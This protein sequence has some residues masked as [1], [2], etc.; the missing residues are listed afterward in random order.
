[1]I[2]VGAEAGCPPLN[3]T[4]IKVC[5][6]GNPMPRKGIAITY[7]ENDNNYIV[8]DSVVLDKNF[9]EM[10]PGEKKS[11][12][13]AHHEKQALFLH[14]LPIHKSNS[15]S[16]S[17]ATRESAKNMPG[18][19]N[20]YYLDPVAFK[21]P[22]IQYDENLLY[23]RFKGEASKGGLLNTTQAQELIIEFGC[24]GIQG[25]TQV[26]ITI[27]ITMHKPIILYMDKEC[28]KETLIDKIEEI[29]VKEEES[30]GI[31]KFIGYVILIGG[32]IFTVITAVNLNSGKKLVDSVPIGGQ[33]LA[34]IL[35][36]VFFNIFST[37]KGFNK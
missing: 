17:L 25:K 14:L 12:I 21:P 15:A 36:L 20:N 2:K 28:S 37:K 8:R 1:M 19:L 34:K 32:I 4:W 22:K 7:H 9:M 11:V 33:L 23:P 16:L 29:V 13:G 35:C 27:E 3:F 5:G 31:L 6:S 26:I 10:A 18:F 24:L 30:F